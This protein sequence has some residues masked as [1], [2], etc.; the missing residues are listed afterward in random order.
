MK[1]LITGGA[2]FL[3]Q[4]LARELLARGELKGPDGQSQPITEL[5]LLDASLR[6][7]AST[8]TTGCAP[9]WATSL[10]AACSSV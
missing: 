2:G 4:R 9:K 6:R 1:V 8:A 5:V 10:S 7:A 3:G